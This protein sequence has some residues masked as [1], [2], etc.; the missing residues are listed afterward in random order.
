MSYQSSIYKGCLRCSH[1]ISSYGCLS[2]C[3]P[4]VCQFHDKDADKK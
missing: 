3:N 4:S 2:K 1:Y